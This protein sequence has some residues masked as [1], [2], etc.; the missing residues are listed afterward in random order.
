MRIYVVGHKS[1]DLDAT[2]APVAY[3][4]YLTKVKRYKD[5]EIIPA[6]V[7]DTN[8]ETAFV[9]Q[10][11]NLLRPRLLAIEEIKPE[12]KIIL[13]DHNEEDQ[14]MDD[15]NNEQ[16]IEIVDHH[17]VKLD[18]G[19]PI[20]LDIRP[21][22]S[23]CSVIYENFVKDELKPSREVMG[24]ILCSILSDTQGLK[25]STTTKWDAKAAHDLAYE[26]DE[27]LDQLTF[28]IFKAKSDMTGLSPEQIVKK[29]YKIFDF[30]RIK[31]FIGQVET[32]EP[33][34]IFAVKDQVIEAMIKVKATE[35]V[36]HIFLTVT[37]ILK[38]NSVV[39]YN[40]DEDKAV[41]EEAFKS[42]G[43]DHVINIGPK[44]SRKKD[45]APPIE[46]A[47]RYK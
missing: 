24:L 26:L 16:V 20:R 40:T 17:K 12:D 34:N 29:D 11:Y 25:S 31:V 43:N 6:V 4:E 28:D 13:V 1:P 15:L 35:G 21:F 47:L 38:V 23:V 14:R 18:F 36:D 19:H 45:I 41:L 44:M 39:F 3:V 2:S 46:D 10:K 37:D 30:S 22:G 8:K 42:I 27:D 5:A 9:F 33:E 32:V 7:D